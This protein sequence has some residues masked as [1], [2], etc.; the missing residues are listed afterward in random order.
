MSE[1]LLSLKAA[2][3]HQCHEGLVSARSGH[4]Q[5]D[6]RY[7]PDI[8][9]GRFLLVLRLALFTLLDRVHI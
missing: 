1:R 7:T 4:L 5:F 2:A 3:E 8:A 9:A 6:V